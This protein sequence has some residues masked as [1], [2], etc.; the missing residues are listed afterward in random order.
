MKLIVTIDLPD[1]A[2]HLAMAIEDRIQDCVQRF[3]ETI[4]VSL[5]VYGVR[6]LSDQIYIEFRDRIHGRE[7]ADESSW[8]RWFKRASTLKGEDP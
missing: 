8:V 7:P 6:L 3:S 2:A 4:H 1:E 5:Q